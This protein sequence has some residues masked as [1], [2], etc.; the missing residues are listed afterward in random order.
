MKAIILA[1]IAGG[2][3][4][5]S[6]LSFK[7][8][9][10]R[11]FP[12][13]RGATGWL[14]SKPLNGQD[15]H[16]KVVLVDFWT[17]TCINWMRT[18]PYTRAWEKKYRQ[19]GLVVIGVHTPEFSFEKKEANVGQALL[20]RNI[21]FPVV[22]DNNHAVWDTFN[23]NYWPALYLM[24]ANGKIRHRE[25]GEGHYE[26][27]EKIIQQLLQEAGGKNIDLPPLSIEARGPEKPADWENLQSGENYLGFERTQNFVNGSKRLELNEWTFSGEWRHG[28]ESIISKKP[29]G[30]IKY[31]FHARDLH[32]VMGPA[33]S[34][35]KI[36][37]KIS[38]DGL[39]PGAS[40]GSDTDEQ[41]NGTLT[42]QRLY[43]LVRQE[44]I[45]ADR[46]FEIEFLD[47]RAEAFSFTFG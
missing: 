19:Q 43:Q 34:G 17:Y 9:S 15:L 3:F 14:N 20:D 13:F 16:G 26:E 47:A 18:L 35:T 2:V 44:G 30:K 41:G 27:T 37:F 45:I 4:C 32:L 23:N 10:M 1:L 8:S 36:R 42:N 12:I 28:Q 24:D 31:R 7:E 39:P 46:T 22:L 38:I 6:S 21:N 33:K 25:F 5:V 40:H 11:E 29:N